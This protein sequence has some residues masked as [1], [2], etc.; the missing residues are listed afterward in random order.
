MVKPF[1]KNGIKTSVTGSCTVRQVELVSRNLTT[2]FRKIVNY[3]P[4]FIEKPC[5]KPALQNQSQSS[6]S[7]KLIRSKLHQLHKNYSSFLTKLMK[8]G[9]SYNVFHIIDLAILAFLFHFIFISFN[10]SF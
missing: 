6:Q 2:V 4:K 9:F 1:V 10:S 8:P 3:M 5:I 7:S